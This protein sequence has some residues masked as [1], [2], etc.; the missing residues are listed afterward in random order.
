MINIIQ[1]EGKNK[2]E[3]INKILSENNISKSEL[4][5]SEELIESKLF[6]SQKYLIKAVK[7][8]DIK[9]YIHNFLNEIGKNMNISI[10]CEILL[11]GDIYNVVIV[12]SKNSVMIGKD[13]KTLN[14]IQILLRQSI[15]NMTNMNIKVNLDISNYKGKKLKILERE[16]RKIAKEVLNSKI[17]ASLDPMNSYERRYVHNIINEYE[18]LSTQSFGEG[19]ERHVVIKYEEASK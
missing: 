8:V 5:I 6:K 17:D 15:K 11:D 13:G 18:N 10:Q 4:F 2:E 16:V 3:V 9:E 7:K 12:S 1:A 14:A 19:K